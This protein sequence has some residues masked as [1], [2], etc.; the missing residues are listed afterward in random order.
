LFAFQQPS[1]TTSWFTT[2]GNFWRSL[3]RPGWEDDD[4]EDQKWRKELF[5]V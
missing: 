4:P 1:V 2:L 3:S 5:K